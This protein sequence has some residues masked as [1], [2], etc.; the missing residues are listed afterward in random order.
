MR[1]IIVRRRGLLPPLRNAGPRPGHGRVNQGCATL[2]E[3]EFPPS[4]CTQGEGWGGGRRPNGLRYPHPYPP[5]EYKGRGKKRLQNVSRTHELIAFDLRLVF[6]SMNVIYGI[7][8]VVGWTWCL[9]AAAF[10]FLNLRK[11]R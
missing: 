8:S 10:L 2:G 11:N 3:K 6:Y 4:P 7:L 9:V 5:P 1:E